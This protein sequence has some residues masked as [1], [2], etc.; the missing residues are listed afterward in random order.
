MSD[1]K[2]TESIVN[3]GFQRS[4][5]ISCSCGLSIDIANIRKLSLSVARRQLEGM[6][7]N[8]T[9]KKDRKILMDAG[10]SLPKPK[11]PTDDPTIQESEDAWNE[12]EK[13]DNDMTPGEIVLDNEDDNKGTKEE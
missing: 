1:H 9:P 11:K 5:T 13:H 2:V 3:A 10:G 7:K 6:H 12:A 4:A 8:L